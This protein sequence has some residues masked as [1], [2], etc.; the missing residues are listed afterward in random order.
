MVRTASYFKFTVKADSASV[1]NIEI[2]KFVPTVSLCTMFGVC[3]YVTSQEQEFKEAVIEG[4]G[5]ENEGLQ[6]GKIDCI[7]SRRRNF[8][9]F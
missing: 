4:F 7:V 2:E 8:S 6:M 5:G 1:R 3:K 9:R